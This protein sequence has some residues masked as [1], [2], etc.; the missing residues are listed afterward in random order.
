M[1]DVF[2]PVAVAGHGTDSSSDSTT[3]ALLDKKRTFRATAY[4]TGTA[5][6]DHFQSGDDVS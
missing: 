2:V 5:R 4:C 3:A 1:F 6:I